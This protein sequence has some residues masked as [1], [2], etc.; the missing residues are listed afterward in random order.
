VRACDDGDWGPGQIKRQGLAGLYTGICANFL[1][2]LNP[3]IKHCVFDQVLV[4]VLCSLSRTCLLGALTWLSSACFDVLSCLLSRACECL[5][6]ASFVFLFVF[7]G[8]LLP[9]VDARTHVDVDTH[10]ERTLKPCGTHAGQSPTPPSGWRQET[11]ACP[12]GFVC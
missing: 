1:L 7:L 4:P 8:V 6:S 10:A 11:I 9:F 12:R 3:A 5:S 2:C